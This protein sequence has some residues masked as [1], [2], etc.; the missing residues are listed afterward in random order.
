MKKTEIPVFSVEFPQK[1][2]SD[3]K[4]LN[5]SLPNVKHLRVVAKSNNNFLENPDLIACLQAIAQ[6]FRGTELYIDYHPIFGLTSK[7]FEYILLMLESNP[8]L[9]IL[10][11]TNIGEFRLS[12]SQEMRFQKVLSRDDTRLES[13]KISFAGEE[14]FPKGSETNRL[15]GVLNSRREPEAVC[16][17]AKKCLDSD[18]ST[19]S[20]EKIVDSLDSLEK[21]P[22]EKITN[23]VSLLREKLTDK[24][25][26]KLQPLSLLMNHQ[27][28]KLSLRA[29]THLLKSTNDPEILLPILKVYFYN[30]LEN[31]IISLSTI[32][33]FQS[34]PANITFQNE[35]VKA[36][37]IENIFEKIINFVKRQKDKDVKTDFGECVKQ[38]YE[39]A[40]IEA[41]SLGIT[42]EDI[43]F[44][45]TGTK[46]LM[47]KPSEESN[48]ASSD[49]DSM[50]M[51]IISH[52]DNPGRS[53][54]NFQKNR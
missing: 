40:K 14:T 3:L 18:L 26:A 30:W 28:I 34:L 46:S 19:I 33:M 15:I 21:I 37:S 49:E 35:M 25:M 23:E 44:S 41:S 16:S 53:S 8:E 50:E 6:S 12:K 43:S 13:I 2:P 38:L 29:A 32:K 54:L 27:D 51:K 11:I 42:L 10:T 47:F 7:Y 22:P 31:K 4:N 24:L 52:T 17:S 9:K 45:S 1:N 20:V 5:E 48:P 36:T 39:R